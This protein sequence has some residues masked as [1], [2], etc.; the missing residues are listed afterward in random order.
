MSQSDTIKPE[1]KTI[2]MPAS[3]YYKLVE[4]TGM[5]NAVTGVNFS[6]S[7]ISSMLIELIYQNSY[8]EFLKLIND[9][10]ALQKNKEQFQEGTKK[11]YDLFKNVRIREV[12]PN[13]I[14]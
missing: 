13:V 3:S 9:P 11:V 7:D 14:G 10:E 1:F 6:L 5:V 8:P 2:R 12:N 4:L